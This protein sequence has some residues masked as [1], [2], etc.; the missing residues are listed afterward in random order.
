MF[1]HARQARTGRNM[2]KSSSP[3]AP[4]TW[5]IFLCPRT[6]AKTSESLTFIRTRETERKYT[7]LLL[8]LLCIY[9]HYTVLILNCKINL[10]EKVKEKVKQSHY[11]PWQALRVPVA[12]GS[13]ISRQSAHEGGKVVSPT[14]RPPWLPQEIFLVLISVRCWVNHRIIIIIFS[15]FAAQ[16]GLWPP[17]FTRFLDHTQRRATVGRTPL[18]EWLTRRGDL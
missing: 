7:V 17:R 12:W 10:Y 3:N 16:R 9:L 18:D 15:G 2:V 1:Q 8:L 4:S 6:Y 13:Q 14:H 5:L 11:S